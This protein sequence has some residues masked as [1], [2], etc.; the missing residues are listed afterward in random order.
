MRRR[1]GAVHSR[2]CIPGAGPGL[3][4]W[5]GFSRGAWR[6]HNL[7]HGPGRQVARPA[8][9]G[10]R[11]A[12]RSGEAAAGERQGLA[13]GREAA[14]APG[15]LDD[16]SALRPD[17][18]DCLCPCTSGIRTKNDGQLKTYTWVGAEAM[19]RHPLSAGDL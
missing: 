11:R 5:D 2:P 17:P 15:R 8:P 10:E 16:A 7:G 12:S 19:A 4:A 14:S 1:C 18:Q 3:G 6:A 13:G 9:G